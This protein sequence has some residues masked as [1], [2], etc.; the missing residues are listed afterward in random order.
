MD[1]KRLPPLQPPATGPAETNGTGK[2]FAP[3]VDTPA[4]KSAAREPGAVLDE[5]LNRAA[6]R[7]GG[8]PDEARHALRAQLSEDPFFQSRLTRYLQRTEE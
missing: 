6:E 8:L 2:V 7:M 3:K 4:V 1:I 5:L